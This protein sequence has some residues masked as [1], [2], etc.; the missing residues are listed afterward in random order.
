MYESDKPYATA[1]AAMLGSAKMIGAGMANAI[2][3]PEKP[4][5]HHQIDH[6]LKVL[7]HC[8][9]MANGIERFADRILGPVPQ[10]V[11]KSAERAP[12]DT[13]ERRL[14]ELSEMAEG[15]AQRLQ[16]AQQRLDSA[17]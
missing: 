4:R 5:L 1:N 2:K 14:A 11:G 12:S 8:H 6:L 16:H 9:E 13:I 17:A 15:L 7:S 3:Q 10:D